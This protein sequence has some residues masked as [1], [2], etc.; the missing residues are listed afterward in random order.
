MPNLRSNNT[1][2]V[3]SALARATLPRR[4]PQHRLT[5]RSIAGL[6]AALSLFLLAGLP[7]AA[8][9]AADEASTIIQA[10]VG[11]ILNGGE[12]RIVGAP[13][14]STVVLPAFY[15]RRGF[16][17]AWTDPQNVDALFVAIL[18]SATDGLTPE[19]YHLSVLE[20]L[21]AAPPGATRDAD[22]DMLAT[23]AIVR[24]AY[25][26]RFGKVDLAP[27]DPQWNFDRDYESILLLSPARRI[28]EALEQQR[29]GDA[30]AA[31]RPSHPLYQALRNTLQT[32][33]QIKAGGGWN[34]IAPGR[35]I[36]PGES[37][38]RVPAVRAR[39]AAEGDL[40]PEP[41]ESGEA[42]GPSLEAALRRFQER[43]SLTQ[44]GSMGGK[45]LRTLNVPVDVRIDQLRL[46]LERSR[47]IMHGL[48]ERLVV[49]NVPA[50]RLYYVEQGGV[51]F[52]TNVVVGK[53]YS[54]TPI[55]RAEMTHAVI[56]PSWTVPPM[57]MKREIIPGL[58]RNPGYLERKGL[59]RV[60]W[61][62]VQPPGPNNA[63]GSIKLMFPNPHFVY[64]HDTPQKALFERDARTF[65][66]GCVRVRDVLDLAEFVIGDPANW[67]KAKLL[68][69][70]RDGATRTVILKQPVP[71]LLAYWTAGVS[72]EGRAFFYEDVY[73]R[74]PAE[75]KALNAPF[76][77]H[78]RAV[79]SAMRASSS[80]SAPH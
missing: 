53:L 27:I 79:S 67:S 78:P 10:R 57:V 47:L 69:T 15:E 26:L 31:L 39:L 18:D 8:V 43:H 64:L 59:Q 7:P 9:H 61:Q 42:Y 14:A 22:F 34:P 60:G 20:A 44:D 54:K 41:E 50:F 19:D 29:L 17:P 28:Q 5:G 49:V 21:R 51:L 2:P 75:L 35:T 71:V 1:T 40:G 3:P 48:P 62:I 13:I 77:F 37:D 65:S 32:Y 46:S 55:F 6:V 24:L 80:P 11:Q 36:R 4:M 25:H 73:G 66:H 58:Q 68:E 52:A 74:D 12:V 56:N 72:P 33:R 16:Q 76:T 23:D 45:T 38:P 30:L 63:L 70:V